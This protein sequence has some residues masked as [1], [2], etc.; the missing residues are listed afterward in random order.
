M[1]KPTVEEVAHSLQVSIGLLKRRLR[2]SPVEGELT[3]PET[4]A[5]AW[6]E[7]DGSASATELA[8]L[9][10]ISPQ[11]MGATLA[12]LQSRGLVHRSPDPGD[13]RK[14]II[15]ITEAGMEALR[16]RRD[17]RTVQLAHALSGGFSAEELEQLM[18]IA[19]LLERLAQRI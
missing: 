11:S 10:Q 13:G 9:E 4:S 5:L 1:A 14:A 15:T 6:L 2:L 8:R 19:P 3:V 17:E 16:E 12:A 18:A 7:R